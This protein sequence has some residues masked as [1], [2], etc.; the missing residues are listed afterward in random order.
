MAAPDSIESTKNPFA[1]NTST[2][3]RHVSHKKSLLKKKIFSTLDW[4]SPHNLVKRF[5][6]HSVLEQIWIKCSY[7]DQRLP[8][9]ESLYPIGL[10]SARIEIPHIG[11]NYIDFSKTDFYQRPSRD[12]WIAPAM[13]FLI[14]YFIFCLAL[15]YFTS[16]TI[17]CN[18]L[19]RTLKYF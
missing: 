10:K 4:T 3:K 5:L 11:S 16:P 14:N 7:L 19:M 8:Q 13:Y 12:H 6:K 17:L 9:H 1:Q 18:F 2:K 15:Y